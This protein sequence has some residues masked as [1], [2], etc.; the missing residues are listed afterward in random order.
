MFELVCSRQA[1]ITDYS[2][3]KFFKKNSNTKI[4]FFTRMGVGRHHWSNS[5]FE[6]LAFLENFNRL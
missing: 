4:N 6:S 5:I 3:L 1:Y 2:V